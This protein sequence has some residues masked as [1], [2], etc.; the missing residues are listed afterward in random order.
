MFISKFSKTFQYSGDSQVVVL[1]SKKKNIILTRVIFVLILNILVP[2]NT[3]FK[4]R[5]N[6]KYTIPD[7][8]VNIIEAH[9]ICV[10]VQLLSHE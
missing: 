9:Y 10:V 4:G 3:Y 5:I 6:T 8:D 7:I 1:R 2:Q